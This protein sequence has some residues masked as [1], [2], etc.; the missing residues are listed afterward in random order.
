MFKNYKVLSLLGWLYRKEKGLV[1]HSVSRAVCPLE[2]ARARIFIP[3]LSVVP[4]KSW[5]WPGI[6]AVWKRFI[7][8]LVSASHRDPKSSHPEFRLG[9]LVH[10]SPWPGSDQIDWLPGASHE[11]QRETEVTHCSAWRGTQQV[12]CFPYSRLRFSGDQA[13]Q[14]ILV[15]LA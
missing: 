6:A 13:L 12:T 4:C 11:A 8:L 7:L 9:G 10:L 2:R 3:F 15:Y 5:K 1:L 14:V